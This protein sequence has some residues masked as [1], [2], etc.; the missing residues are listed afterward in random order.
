MFATVCTYSSDRGWTW[1]LE[2][3]WRVWRQDGADS[4]MILGSMTIIALIK[5]QPQVAFF[6][7]MGELHL[8]NFLQRVS[9]VSLVNPITSDTFH[10]PEFMRFL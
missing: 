4:K 3:Q 9:G 10:S 8:P 6:F 2:V 1:I 5:S 7:L